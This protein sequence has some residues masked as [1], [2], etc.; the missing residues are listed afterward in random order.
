MKL[1]NAGYANRIERGFRNL[2]GQYDNER[3]ANLIIHSENFDRVD[4][5]SG[6][7]DV[8]CANV[9]KVCGN[10]ARTLARMV[11]ELKVK[12]AADLLEYCN[13]I[14]NEEPYGP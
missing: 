12:D 10:D 7:F 6:I 9:I 8:E 5:G 3:V 2:V 13:R 1:T 14:V 11:K 4:F